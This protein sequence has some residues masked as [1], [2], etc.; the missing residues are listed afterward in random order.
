MSR[1]PGFLVYGLLIGVRARFGRTPLLV[2]PARLADQGGRGPGHAPAPAREATSW[3]THSARWTRS[4]SGRRWAT[5]CSSRRWPRAPSSSSARSPATPSPSSASAGNGPLLVFV[6]A[7]MAVPDPARRRPALHPDVQARLGGQH[8]LGRSSLAGHGVRRVLHAAVPRRRRARRAGRGGPHG[9]VL[10]DPHVLGGRRTSGTTGRR[11]LVALHLHA[12][13]DRLLLA[14]DRA[15]ARQ[16]HRS[17]WPSTN[18]RA[19]TS[20]TSAWSWPG[21]L[22]AT[23]PLLVLFVVAGRQLVS[24]IMQGAVKG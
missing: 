4:R 18:S 9:R 24:G 3:P 22:L 5:A 2:L 6:I 16:P 10:A 21:P 17:R 23:V 19:G 8:L 12:G 13:V 1:R 11:D 15:A 20:R 7:T 14:A